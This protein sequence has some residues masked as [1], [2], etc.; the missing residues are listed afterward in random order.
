[1]NEYLEILQP[2]EIVLAGRIGV[3]V[4]KP[5]DTVISSYRSNQSK[6]WGEVAKDLGI[7]PGSPEFHALKGKPKKNQGKGNVNSNKGKGKK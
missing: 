5:V 1:L 2:A 3:I 6:G 7:K 4:D